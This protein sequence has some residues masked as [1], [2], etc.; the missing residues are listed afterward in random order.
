[1]KNDRRKRQVEITVVVLVSVL[2]YLIWYWHDGVIITPDSDSYLTMQADREPGYCFYLWLMQVIFGNK[3]YLDAAAVLQCI[4]AGI[5][6]AV[7]TVSLKKRFR[8]N[9]I[10]IGRAHV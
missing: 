2:F 9:N 6:T 4:I 8:L 5:S 3:R 7:F 1:M 10:K